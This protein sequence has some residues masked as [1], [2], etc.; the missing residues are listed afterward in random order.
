MKT[1]ELKKII[2]GR[3]GTSKE[4]ANVIKNYSQITNIVWNLKRGK[5]TK[6]EKQRGCY[7]EDYLDDVITFDYKGQRYLLESKY[8]GP[9]SLKQEHTLSKLENKDILCTAQ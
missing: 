2:K 1:I 7:L 3:A 5:A 8:T 9:F 4:N 6:K